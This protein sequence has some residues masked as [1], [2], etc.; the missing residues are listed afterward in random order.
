MLANSAKVP[1]E[2]GKLL[3]SAKSGDRKLGK[4]LQIVEKCYQITGKCWQ[5]A[6][7]FVEIIVKCVADS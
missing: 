1:V 3:L 5:F 6:G 4:Y 2:V 7:N